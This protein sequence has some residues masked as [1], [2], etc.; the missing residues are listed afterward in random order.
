VTAASAVADGD[1]ASSAACHGVQQASEALHAD[2]SIQDGFEHGEELVPAMRT[3]LESTF[4]A[5]TVPGLSYLVT[6]AGQQDLG[7]TAA[8]SVGST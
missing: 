7:N 5:P 8:V 1:V 3:E 4:K 6:D 2:A